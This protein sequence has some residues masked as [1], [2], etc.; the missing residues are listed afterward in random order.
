MLRPA[1]SLNYMKSE[2]KYIINKMILIM[3][4]PRNCNHER[5]KANTSETWDTISES[6]SLPFAIKK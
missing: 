4:G 5:K 6:L 3:Q 1:V 2:I